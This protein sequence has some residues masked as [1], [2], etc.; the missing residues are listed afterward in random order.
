MAAVDDKNQAMRNMVAILYDET[1]WQEKNI[2][3]TANAPRQNH[4]TTNRQ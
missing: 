3:D 2:I 1:I 4:T